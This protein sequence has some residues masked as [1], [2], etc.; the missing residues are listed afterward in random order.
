M[1]AGQVDGFG[2]DARGDGDGVVWVGG[3][4]FCGR[5]VSPTI[6]VWTKS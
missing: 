1:L 3:D 6:F 4:G 2:R 5:E